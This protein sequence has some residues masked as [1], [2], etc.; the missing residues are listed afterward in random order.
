MV[1]G[2]LRNS[3]LHLGETASLQQMAGTVVAAAGLTVIA[4][5]VT[6]SLD[7][8][9]LLGLACV[10]AGTICWAVGNIIVRRTANVDMLGFVTWLSLAPPLPLLLLSLVFEGEGAILSSLANFRWWGA[11]ILLFLGF[12]ATTAGFGGWGHLI[13]LYGAAAVSP[14]ALL[15]PIFGAISSWLILGETFGPARLSGMA[16]IILGLVVLLSA[17]RPRSA[18]SMAAGAAAD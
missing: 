3:G 8:V 15:V 6:G 2:L 7:D 11:G 17:M 10:M 13:K 12:G 16:L 4:M 1:G 18:A 9:T 14:F 5:S